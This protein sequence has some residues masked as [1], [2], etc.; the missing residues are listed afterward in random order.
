MSDKQIQSQE[1]LTPVNIEVISSI[2]AK[3]AVKE[4]VAYLASE[5][6]KA[7]NADNSKRIERAIKETLDA[8]EKQRNDLERKKKKNMVKNTELLITH[9]RK[10]KE[11]VREIDLDKLEDEGTFLSSEELTLET[12][13]R[14]RYKTYKM[15][16]HIENM[17][18][19][20]DY[21]TKQGT[22][23]ER[24]R[25]L[26][27]QRRYIADNRM[28]IKEIME[29]MNVSQST[30]YSDSKKAMQDMSSFIFGYESVMFK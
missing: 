13:E 3:E 30:V 24:R 1:I 20:Y 25:F 27:M 12:L 9:F 19:A 26:I 18:V 23:E 10:C 15:V 8:H 4:T 11:M 17:L 7:L 28:S 22:Q 2:A 16:R 5:T 21:D 29:H 14:Y 6:F